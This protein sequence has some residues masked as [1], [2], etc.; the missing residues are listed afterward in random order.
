GF[1]RA[2]K[3]ITLFFTHNLLLFIAGYHLKLLSGYRGPLYTIKNDSYNQLICEN[4]KENKVNNFLTLDGKKERSYE[5]IDEGEY[6][7][8]SIAIDSRSSTTLNWFRAVTSG[9]Y[10]LSIEQVE[11]KTCTGTDHA[12]ATIVVTPNGKREYQPI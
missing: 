11:C 4:M 9:V 7:G 5:N 3:N 10:T 6:I 1:L 8:C 2:G 12:W